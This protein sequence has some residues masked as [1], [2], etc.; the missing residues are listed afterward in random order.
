V[1]SRPLSYHETPENFGDGGP[2]GVYEAEEKNQP[3]ILITQQSF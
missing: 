2:D 1:I 3:E